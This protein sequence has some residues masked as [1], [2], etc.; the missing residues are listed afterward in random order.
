MRLGCAALV[1]VS[2][3]PAC[4]SGAGDGAPT[5]AAR[6][7]VSEALASTRA[8]A[9]YVILAQRQVSPPG[10]PRLR[11]E[12]IVQVEDALERE[13][14]FAV[15][16]AAEAEAYRQLPM[17]RALLL[18]VIVRRDGMGVPLA[19]AVS[20]ADG[21]GWTGDGRFGEVTD[22]GRIEVD[23]PSEGG[24]ERYSLPRTGP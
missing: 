21:L 1:C 6:P 19:V 22:S 24:V 11:Y 8:A 20:S 18:Q 3:L 4:G 16:R 10:D 12:K 17:L 14:L 13:A 7:G 2:L 5:P 23:V 9:R 15:V